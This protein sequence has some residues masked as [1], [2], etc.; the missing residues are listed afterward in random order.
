MA[1]TKT[2]TTKSMQEPSD[3][4][5]ANIEKSLAKAKAKFE[6]EKQ[7]EVSIPKNFKKDLGETLYLNINGTKIVLP[8]DGSKHK[9]PE[10]FAD[11]LRD[12]LNGI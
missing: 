3:S 7:L 10:S 9:V 4:L 11:H 5:K 1:E 12:Y 6:K 8:V 2:N